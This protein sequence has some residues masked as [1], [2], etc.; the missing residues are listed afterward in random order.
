V[1]PLLL[2]LILGLLLPVPV[3]ADF[4]DIIT[5]ARPAGMGG[6]FVGLADDVNAL[7]W[8]P[9]GLTLSKSMQLGM[10]RADEMSP[11]NGPKVTTDFAGWTSGNSC[12]GAAGI[13]FLRQGLSNIVEERTLGAS[14]GLAV[15]PFTRLGLTLKSMATI[16]NPQGHFF[17]DP[18]LVN[19]STMGLDVGAIQVVTPDLRF[20]FL[21][22]NLFAHSGV[23][24]REDVRKTYRLGAA[25]K[26]HTELIDEDYLWLTCDVFTKEDIKDEAG[27]AIRSSIGAE[28]Q[29]TP[30]M[31]LRAGCDRGRFTAGGGVSALGI[32][33][34]YAFAQ[35]QEGI[36]TSQ[37]IS[38]LYR[39]DTGGVHVDRQEVHVRHRE[40]PPYKAPPAFEARPPRV[41]E[42]SIRREPQG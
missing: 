1:R 4:N 40:E 2:V 6:A 13:S 33:I 5:G 18:A 39:F 15:T 41:P 28:W 34:D 42:K 24:Q 7:Y 3:R 23:V 19:S 10:M 8:N 35:D 12:R 31:A 27:L 30:W 37:R 38:L 17:P 22:R 9:A 20:G 36:G 21:A 32:S 26:L 29:L 11:T 14:Y 16:T 25:Y